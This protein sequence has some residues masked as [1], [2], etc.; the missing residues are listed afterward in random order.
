[1]KTAIVIGASGLIGKALTQQ[2]INLPQYETVHI[3]VRKPIDLQHPKL[4]Q[5]IIDFDKMQQSV[6]FIKGDEAFCCLGTTMKQAGS[7]EKFYRV[8]YEYVNDFARLCSQQG[9]KK[10]ALV[11]SMGADSKSFIYYNQVKGAIE[12]K[13]SS[14]NFETTI[15]CRPSMLVGNRT[16]KRI[17]E[18]IGIVIGNYLSFLIPA[19]YKN[20]HVE[21]VAKAMISLANSQLKGLQIVESD[22]LQTY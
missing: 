9:I 1:M 19:K 6:D 14:Y 13:I 2:L 11:S 10:F 18:E 22:K 7:K 17:G 4:Q 8:D 15:I 16:E 5:H 12:Q 21:Q 20:I 3:L